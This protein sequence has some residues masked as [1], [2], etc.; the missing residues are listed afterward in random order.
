MS[1]TIV[2]GH[3][4][5]AM[6]L[7]DDPTRDFAAT[8]PAGQALSLPGAEQGGLALIAATVF[9]VHSDKQGRKAA[10]V[11]RQQLATYDA[12]L[13]HHGTRLRRVVSQRDLNY[14]GDRH[15]L[16]FLH[17]MEGADPID[18]PDDL[19][20]WVD[21]GVRIIGLAWNTG[22]QYCGG[23]VDRSGLTDMGRDLLR[24]MRSQHVIPD[25]SHLTPEAF[26]SVATLDDELVIASHSNAKAICDHRRNLS[27]EQLK[28]VADRGGVVG[29]VL[30][31]PFVTDGE[32]T[33]DDVVRHVD[34]MASLIGVNHIG[35]GSDLDGG[36]DTKDTPTEI[37]CV[38]H[39]GKI[40]DALLARG[41]ARD[42]VAGIMGANWLRVY[43]HAF[44]KGTSS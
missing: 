31:R 33:L 22:N 17:L 35:I 41:Y 8:P 5:I 10:H 39:L 37:G 26:E 27:D 18:S 4:D 32:A 2:D 12:L 24:A 44:P 14:I 1:W 30:Y 9:A 19:A 7:M 38:S 28:L 15:P 25:M 16:A 11:A 23:V 13:E 36:F 29:I 20:W 34:Y 43:A 40:G 6:A 42:D 3:Q 21:R